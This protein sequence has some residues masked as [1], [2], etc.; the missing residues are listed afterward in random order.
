MICASMR[1]DRLSA[2]LAL[3]RLQTWPQT[4][5][6]IIANT[7]GYVRRSEVTKAELGDTVVLN[8]PELSLGECLN[9]GVA[10]ASGEVV[11]K[12][13]DDDLYSA[14]YLSATIRALQTAE[15]EVTGQK[16]NF[17]YVTQLDATYLRDPGN[18]NCFVG[19]LA[20]G[21][22]ATLRSVAQ[23][24]GFAALDVGEDGDFIRR[25]ERSGGRIWSGSAGNY[26]QIRNEP[27]GHAW[28][29]DHDRFLAG[30][31]LVGTGHDSDLW[32]RR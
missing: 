14:H 15:A 1:P 22:I 18:E 16:T 21:T 2:V 20:G 6:I 23:E 7:A 28:T 9:A 17:A 25:V 19:R 32:V 26:L 5:L 4:E 13:D 27:A 24:I 29:A 8:H 12:V 30:A 10:A 11:A 3:A 31:K